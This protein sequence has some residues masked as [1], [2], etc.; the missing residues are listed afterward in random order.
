LGNAGSGPGFASQR[1]RFRYLGTFLDSPADEV[2]AHVVGQSAVTVPTC[3]GCYGVGVTR[4]DRVSEI[5]AACGCRDF[6]D[7]PGLPG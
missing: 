3:P 1:G 2:D 7:Q 4:R 6:W 5:N